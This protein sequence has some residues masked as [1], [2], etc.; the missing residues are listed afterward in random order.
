M[1]KNSIYWLTLLLALFEYWRSSSRTSTSDPFKQIKRQVVVV[2]SETSTHFHHT[3]PI[4]PS[5]ISDDGR[6]LHLKGVSVRKRP[7]HQTNTQKQVRHYTDTPKGVWANGHGCHQMKECFTFT[8]Q[9]VSVILVQNDFFQSYRKSEHVADTAH[10][11]HLQ[12]PISGLNKP[13]KTWLFEWHKNT[14]MKCFMDCDL[15]DIIWKTVKFL[16]THT[17]R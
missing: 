5:F 14:L 4:F 2:Y 15:K 7:Q 17:R 11:E 9:L 8:K 13:T 3:R 10:Q 6:Y 16:Y 12:K 1:H